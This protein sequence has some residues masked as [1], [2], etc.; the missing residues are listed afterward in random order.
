MLR[1]RSAA[2]FERVRRDGRSHAHPLV[3]LVAC[4]RPALSWDGGKAGG[5]SVSYTRVGVTAGRGIGTAVARNRA[6]RLLREAMRAH[7]Q[8]IDTGW[9][10]VLIARQ[11]LPEAT[12][13]QA[14]SA[15]RNLL[16]RANVLSTDGTDRTDG[17]VLAIDP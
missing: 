15:I 13:A 3:V 16:G 8:E 6:K 12:L 1:L 11:P 17:S 5:E 9:D 7:E 2:D 10:L 4:R 14:R